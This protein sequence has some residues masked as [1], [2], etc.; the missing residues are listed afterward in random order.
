MFPTPTGG[1]P[2]NLL[3]DMKQGSLVSEMR[4]RIGDA[5]S[6]SP[7]TSYRE[8]VLRTELAFFATLPPTVIY[9]HV[10]VWRLAQNM[11]QFRKFNQGF[12]RSGET[13]VLDIV[14]S[15]MS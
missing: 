7:S 4:N 10:D 13:Q 5:L 3:R 1:K 6:P 8:A 12:I 11:R 9:H 15:C 14:A 2:V